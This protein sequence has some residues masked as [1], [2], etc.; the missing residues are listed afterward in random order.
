V[1]RLSA[2]DDVFFGLKPGIFSLYTHRTILGYRFIPQPSKTPISNWDQLMKL[3]ED[4]FQ[5]SH[6]RFVI[7]D[8]L[9]IQGLQWMGLDQDNALEELIKRYPEHFK[10]IYQTPSQL[11]QLYQFQ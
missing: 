6:V 7:S 4:L 10:P 11:L 8:R 2:P 1:D 5:Q 3:Y 9:N